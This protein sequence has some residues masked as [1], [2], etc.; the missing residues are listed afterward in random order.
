[1]KKHFYTNNEPQN[2]PRGPMS[3]S[4]KKTKEG[5]CLRNECEQCFFFHLA[6]NIWWLWGYFAKYNITVLLTLWLGPNQTN[7]WKSSAKHFFPLYLYFLYTCWNC[8]CS[9]AYI[10]IMFWLLLD[11]KKKEKGKKKSSSFTA[12][13]MNLTCQSQVIQSLIINVCICFEVWF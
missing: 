8:A 10:Y 9:G 2:I 4:G 7:K 3:M 5:N 12:R 11:E 13:W 6:T 1:M